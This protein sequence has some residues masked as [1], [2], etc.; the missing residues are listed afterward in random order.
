M[1]R[2]RDKLAMEICGGARIARRT[3]G[4][5]AGAFSLVEVLLAVMILGIGLVMVAAI[6][7]V[8][9][10]WTRESAEETVGQMVARNATAIIQVRYK[11]GDMA[12]VAA[13]P[14]PTWLQ[15]LPGIGGLPL[16]E[17][18]Y[19]FGAFPPY[20]AS[21]PGHASYYWTAMV[22]QTPSDT[23]GRQFDLFIFVFRKG[24]TEQTFTQTPPGAVLGIG[25]RGPGETGVPT[26]A[27]ADAAVAMDPKYTA[28]GLLAQ[29]IGVQSGTVF[30]KLASGSRPALPSSDSDI[31][32]GPAADGTDGSPLIC[33]YQASLAF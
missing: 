22:R 28:F 8:G 14:H 5:R 13:G 20:P 21:D 31:L 27:S 11:A 16:S 24:Q 7:P 18:A 19:A 29:G 2:L 32:F 33:I 4:A 6:F 23:S 26:L 10:Q 9:A 17:R 15:P 30:K 12:A 1:D 25:L 3:G